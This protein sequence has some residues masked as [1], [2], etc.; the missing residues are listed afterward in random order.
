[1]IDLSH[2]INDSKKEGFCLLHSGTKGKT[3]VGANGKRVKNYKNLKI[4]NCNIGYIAYP[5]P[6]LKNNIPNSRFYEFENVKIITPER[7]RHRSMSPSGNLNINYNTSGPLQTS[8]T[9]KTVHQKNQTYQRA[10]RRGGDLSNVLLYSFSQKILRVIPT[11]SSSN[12]PKP[13]LP[14]FPPT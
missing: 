10:P 1:M 5:N 11:V 3:I 13:I 6:T 9:K 8:V 7:R 12:F 2:Y 14:T 4:K